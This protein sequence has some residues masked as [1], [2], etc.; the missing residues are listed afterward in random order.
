[1]KKLF[2]GLFLSA[3]LFTLTPHS[4]FSQAKPAAGTPLSS[5]TD[6]S[7]YYKFVSLLHSANLDATLN[8]LVAYTIFAPTNLV[9]RDMSASRMDS[10]TSDPAT[11]AKILKTHIVK[12]K[13]SMSDISKKLAAGKGKITLTNILGQPLKLAHN[14]KTNQVTITDASGHQAYFTDF[15]TKDPHAVLHGIDNVLL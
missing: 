1:M 7:K 3:A 12:G 5:I 4:S 8:G 2:L 10:L 6:D 11:L 14:S 15:D 9:F 13:L